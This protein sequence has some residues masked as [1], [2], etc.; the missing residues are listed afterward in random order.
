MSRTPYRLTEPLASP[1]LNSSRIRM[2]P[3][4]VTTRLHKELWRRFG[5]PDHPSEWDGNVYGGGK[6]SQRYWEY[7]KAVEMLGLTP[8]SVVLDIGGGS[9]E[10]GIGFFASLISTAVKRVIVMDSNVRSE[11]DLGNNI[12]VVPELANQETLTEVFKKHPDI[13]QVSS[14][15]VMEHIPHEVRR[16]IMR[17]LNDGFAGDRIVFTLEYHANTNFFEHQLTTRS[18]SDSVGLLNRFYPTRIES[19]PVYAE[20]A[21]IPAHVSKRGVIARYKI[22]KRWFTRAQVEIPCWYPLAVTFERL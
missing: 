8:D 20:N 3:T 2:E 4:P 18:L 14:V 7:F 15:S 16:S 17:G 1:E 6:L 9:P 11:F 12:V 13:T 22:W 5:T 19:A 21:F 10:T